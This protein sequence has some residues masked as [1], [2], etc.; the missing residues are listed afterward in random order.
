MYIRNRLL[1]IGCKIV[2]SRMDEL[3]GFVNLN[4]VISCL[5]YMYIYIYVKKDQ[6]FHPAVILL[7]KDSSSF[8]PGYMQRRYVSF[9]ATG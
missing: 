6:W 9:G 7:D 3:T 8:R 5:Y 2:Q 4:L 1:T